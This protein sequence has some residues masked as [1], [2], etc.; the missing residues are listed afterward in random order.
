[1][2]MNF[3][4]KLK[5]VF[6]GTKKLIFVNVFT[7]NIINTCLEVFNIALLLPLF[8]VAFNQTS[9][10]KQLDIIPEFFFNLNNYEQIIV[11]ILLILSV[12]IIKVF[13]FVFGHYYQSKHIYLIGATIGDNLVK[14]YLHSNL[15]YHIYNSSSVMIRNVYKEVNE[16]IDT[17]IRSSFVLVNDAFILIGI[18]FFL[19]IIDFYKF[20]ILIIF[21]ILIIGLFSFL[22]KFFVRYGSK[23]QFYDETRLRH[24]Q[25]LLRSIREIKIYEREKF[26]FERFSFDNR[27]NYKYAGK[28][29]FLS[30]LP[31]VIIESTVLFLVVVFLLFLLK[32]NKNIEIMNLETSILFL[33]AIIRFIPLISRI[34][35]SANSLKYGLPT[36]DVLTKE[37]LEKGEQKNNENFK[38]TQFF[39]KDLVFKDVTFLYE[40][41]DKP[42]INNLSFKINK[43]DLIKIIGKS[44]SGKTTL[45]NMIIGFLNP[46]KGEILID[47]KP[48]RENY[49]QWISKIGIVSQN[50]FLFNDTIENNIAF[51]SIVNRDRVRETLNKVNLNPDDYRYNPSTYIEENGGNLSGGEIQR[52]SI[53]RSLYNDSDLIIFDEPTSN[54]DT[55]NSILIEQLIYSLKKKK[56]IIVV[57][58]DE[59]L[60][61]D[62]KLT[63]NLN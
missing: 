35:T 40:N 56:T 52:I 32:T 50:I 6:K 10:L 41:K 28:N 19:L 15:S 9:K 5:T 4:Y 48:L 43:G 30:N 23:R 26:F 58:H 55:E 63:I 57:S 33:A 46:E 12:Y 36:L 39:E 1:M 22:R 31:R 20:L 8:S 54:L 37:L 47:G 24:L 16:F 38:Y 45:T 34:N 53:A 25:N 14:K 51:G 21:S 2:K 17:N 59:K 29:L 49:K 44:G 42:I 60:F 62:A 27:E 13:F 7:L 3:L 18:L 11:V 61:K